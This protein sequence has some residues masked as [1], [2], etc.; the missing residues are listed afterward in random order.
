M[1]IIPNN[2]IPFPGFMAITLWPF[3]FVRKKAFSS[4][5]RSVMN[6]ERIHARQQLETLCVGAVI[7]SV[8]IA[9]GCGWWSLLALPLFLWLYGFEWVVL[10]L[11]LGNSHRAYRSVSFEQEAYDNEDDPSY[12]QNRR[13][14]AWLNYVIMH[15]D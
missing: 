13:P 3:I 8:F 4:F 14:F 15:K 9:A 12:L 10:F 7:A 2:I 11:C 6:H 5:T 1:F